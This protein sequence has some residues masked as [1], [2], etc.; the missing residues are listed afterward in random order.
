MTA[1][2]QNGKL[3][4]GD[5]SATCHG[6]SFA[7]VTSPPTIRLRRFANPHLQSVVDPVV[8]VVGVVTVVVDA[9]VDAV[10][11]VSVVDTVERV[12]VEPVLPV[13]AAVDAVEGPL[14][15]H[16]TLHL[17]PSSDLR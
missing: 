17:N 5:T 14:S 7:S 9:V 15:K 12:G 4:P 8:V 6:Y 3:L 11:V 16:L 10:T 2:P 1:P 13:G